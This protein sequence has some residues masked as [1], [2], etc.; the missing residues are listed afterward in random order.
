M[1]NVH[2]V[3]PG[4]ADDHKVTKGGARKMEIN[5]KKQAE[6]YLDKCDS[7]T[8]KKILK[9][10]V[11]ITMGTADIKRIN[12]T[13]KFRAKIEH[14]RIAFTHEQKDDILVLVIWAILPRGEFYKYMER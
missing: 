6:K 14:Y 7:N 9:A 13:D 3:L 4:N 10:I 8:R 2:V 12:G 1:V 11:G 5:Y